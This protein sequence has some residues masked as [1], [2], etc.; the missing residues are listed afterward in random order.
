MGDVEEWQKQRNQWKSSSVDD[1][2]RNS[3]S[4]IGSTW[5]EHHRTSSYIYF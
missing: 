5:Q 3:F 1:P 4:A 2:T